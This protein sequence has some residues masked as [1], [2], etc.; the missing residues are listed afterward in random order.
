MKKSD[1]DIHADFLPGPDCYLSIQEYI[2][3]CP[4]PLL[5]SERNTPM[6]ESL[7]MQ[8]AMQQQMEKALLI[9]NRRAG[10]MAAFTAFVP[11]GYYLLAHYRLSA[12]TELIL[13]QLP[14]WGIRVERVDFHDFNRLSEAIKSKTRLLFTEFPAGPYLDVINLS[15]CADVA[16]KKQTILMVDHSLVS[17]LV[18]PGKYGADLVISSG[19]WLTGQG[20]CIGYIAGAEDLLAFIE[21]ILSLWGSQISPHALPVLNQGLITQNLRIEQQSRTA[22]EI[23]QFFSN[24]PKIAETVYPGLEQHPDYTFARQQLSQFGSTIVW[25]LNT[26]TAGCMRMLSNPQISYVGTTWGTAV[27]TLEYIA[28][29][30]YLPLNAAL[31][32]QLGIFSNVVQI[33]VG[34]ELKQDLLR[35]LEQIL[36]QV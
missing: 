12:A 17:G 35:D 11:S 1:Q 29:M 22:L 16:H 26:N 2:D 13:E 9:P 36:R 27:T 14:R 10:L 18:R 31:K 7:T 15:G 25:K 30:S 5:S 21:D 24:H 19:H 28:A 8:I 6:V 20:D 4:D 32:N 3:N 33:S 23:A 34:L